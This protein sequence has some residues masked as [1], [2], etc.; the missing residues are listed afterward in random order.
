MINFGSYDGYIAD[1][2]LAATVAMTG[3]GQ[4]LQDHLSVMAE[5]HRPDPGPFR[6]NMRFDRAA[7]MVLR[8]Y[9]LGTG[10]GTDLPSGF[11]AFMKTRPELEIP[12]IQFHFSAGNL[13]ALHRRPFSKP[14]TDHTRPDAFMCHACV[15]RPEAS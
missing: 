15:L 5:Y 1:P 2:G 8:A 11:M 3:V 13:L 14:A 10:P 4:N 12:D 6:K 7:L 9:F